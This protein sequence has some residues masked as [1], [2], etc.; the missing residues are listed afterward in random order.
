MFGGR[1][2]GSFLLDLEVVDTKQ[3]APH[4]RSLTM[5]SSDLVGF[6]FAP[7]QDVMIEVPAGDRV[8]RR[9]YTIRRADPEAGTADFEFELHGHGGAAAGWAAGATA[10]S[11]IQAIGPR[12]NIA[13]RDTHSHVFV[14]D[15]SAMPAAFA[16]LE[17]M[18]RNTAARAILVTDHGPDSR[19]GPAAQPDVAIHW[20]E[21]A[22]VV[23]T[24]ASLVV[25]PDASAYVFGERSLVLRA[26]EALAT[27]GL[28][29]DAIASKA[30][31]RSDQPNA[32]HGEPGR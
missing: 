26:T 4:I 13:L 7:G 12:G 2:R 20:V 16:M 18:P 28:T 23:D 30:Y 27:R 8:V 32:D 31:W 1:L 17:A 22:A 15:D 5:A 10:G 11:R 19:P 29:R 24:I 9:R 14:V 25:A 3:L 21:S 6:E